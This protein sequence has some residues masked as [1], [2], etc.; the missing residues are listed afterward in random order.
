MAEEKTIEAQAY[1][2]QEQ[3]AKHE[4]AA[5]NLRDQ[6]MIRITRRLGCRI[7]ETLN[8]YVENI[9]FKRFLITIRH[10]KARVAIACPQCNTRLRKSDSFC[11]HCTAKV[12]AVIQKVI[13]HPKMRTVPV[14]KDTLEMIR[15]YMKGVQLEVVEEKHKLFSLSRQHAWQIFV[16]AAI[17]AGLPKI[18][19]PETE[20]YHNVSPHKL[21][22]AFAVHAMKLNPTMEG[23]R[24]LQE[25]L[26]HKDIGTTMRYRKLA[27][28]EQQDWYDKLFEKEKPSGN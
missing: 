18:Y 3:T 16:E 21:R 26:G 11:P 23:A 17:R 27:L 14:D 24:L 10:Q 12:E 22:D 2:D 20:K 9:D 19:N 13:S 8:L 25:Q 5:K 6:L 28:E 1:L 15:G 4:A 7:S